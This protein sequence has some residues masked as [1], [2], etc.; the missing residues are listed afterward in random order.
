[1]A[2]EMSSHGPKGASMKPAHNRR[3]FA[4]KMGIV[5]SVL[6]VVAAACAASEPTDNATPLEYDFSELEI[7]ELGYDPATEVFVQVSGYKNY[8]S[9][10][11]MVS[12]SDLV[13]R[14]TVE[15][16][17]EGRVVSGGEVDSEIIV[18]TVKVADVL[19]GEVKGGD[20]VSF[21][22]TAWDLNPDGTR[23]KIHLTNGIRVPAV[24][25]ELLLFLRD[26][27][28]DLERSLKVRPSH[29]LITLGGLLN[30]EG[31][32]ISSEVFD[33]SGDEGDPPL[34]VRLNQVSYKDL[35][36]MVDAAK[37]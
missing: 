4:A 3:P 23:G 25:Q 32:R 18:V 34:G 7:A 10:D 26:L 13:V 11:D 36:T 35:K 27:P 15:G 5:T 8:A 14:G 30:V 2:G 9:L 22:W 31:D 37:P 20:I 12:E 6:F 29:Y 24:G 33:G 1:M 16:W 17:E 21:P 28:D 19:V